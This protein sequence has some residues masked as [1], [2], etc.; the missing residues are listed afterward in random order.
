MSYSVDYR[1]RVVEYLAEGHTQAQAQ[2]VFKVGR[3]TIKAWKKL[4]SETGRLEPKELKRS[5]RIY[6]SEKLRTY[7]EN[8]PQ[9][10]LKEIAKEFGGSISGAADALKREK[11]TFKKQHLHT[12]NATRK[13]ERNLMPR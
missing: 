6:D 7:I 3:T 11:I 2:A 8:H 10:T 9:A 1:N 4:L 13:N 12:V 5:A